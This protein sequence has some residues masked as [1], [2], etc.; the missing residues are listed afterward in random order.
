MAED[1][2]LVAT[3]GSVQAHAAVAMAVR[4]ARSIGASLTVLHVVAPLAS[5]AP[6][7]PPGIARVFPVGTMIPGM[8]KP[9]EILRRPG[10]GIDRDTLIA[11]E[12]IVEEAASEARRSGVQ[13]VGA[14]VEAG[15]CAETIVETAR[16]IDASM[17][18]VG[19]RGLGGLAGLFLGSVSEKVAN[20]AHCSVLIAR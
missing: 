6:G 11:G 18:V 1:R 20:H 3:D 16:E 2:I 15:N 8:Q 9:T 10:D 14:R 4:V 5:G 12:Q 19:S 17:I 13:N 7:G